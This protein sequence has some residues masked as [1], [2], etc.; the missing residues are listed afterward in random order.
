MITYRFLSNFPLKPSLDQVLNGIRWWQ[1]WEIVP[2]V[3]TPGVNDVKW[4]L[5]NLQLPASLDGARVLDIGG[6]NGAFSFECERRNAREVVMVEPMPPAATGFDRT[7]AFLESKVQHRQG[8]IYDLDPETIGYFDIVLCLGIIYHL[9]YPLLGLDNIRRICRGQLFVE[10]AI[11]ETAFWTPDGIQP[12]AVAAPGL[13]N[14]SILQFF[15]GTEFFND[16]TNWFVPNVEA[17]NALI[18][19]AG[20]QVLR[21]HVDGRYFC[22][23]RV[24]PGRPPIFEMAH[25]GLDYETHAR[26]LLGPADNW[27][28]IG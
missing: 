4:L 21:S 18:E 24:T 1:K 26:H 19:A 20:F 25:E 27:P 22:H 16:K 8:S 15:R 3:F 28:I 17:A 7:K 23:S 12:L 14:L 2:G 5:D 6:W 11:L 9:R 13:E 10:S